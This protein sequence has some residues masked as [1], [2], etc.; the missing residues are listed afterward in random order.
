M[1][2]PKGPDT[3]QLT[4][5]FRNASL[6]LQMA[7][8]KFAAATERL[9]TASAPTA[10]LQPKEVTVPLQDDNLRQLVSQAVLNLSMQSGMSIHQ[11][12]VLAYDYLCQNTGFNAA[13]W[14]KEGKFKRKLDAVQAHNMLSALHHIVVRMMCTDTFR[15][16]VKLAEL[17]PA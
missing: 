4:F 5:D 10:A 15:G 11:T 1:K 13:Y 9:V 14:M 7:V 2:I 16:Q 3:N 12:W 6:E 8:N 17:S